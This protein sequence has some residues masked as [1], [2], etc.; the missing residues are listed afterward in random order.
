M[1]HSMKFSYL[2]LF[3][4]FMT[5]LS[6]A[7]QDVNNGISVNEILLEYNDSR[8]LV[9][10]EQLADLIIKKDPSLRLID[11]RDE[12]QFESFS[13]PW[14]QNVPLK[15]FLSDSA[16]DILDCDKYKIVCYSNSN[17][18]A[19]RAWMVKR[20]LGCS[21]VYI[22]SGGL[23]AW[24]ENILQPRKPG[25]LASSDEIE[26]YKMRLAMQNY[27]L[28]LSQELEEVPFTRPVPKKSIVVVPKK[29]VEDEEEEGC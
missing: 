14:A 18:L 16:K 22:L 17:I 7:E 11:V 6:C 5:I 12:G 10:P 8:R 29:V 24:V 15:E 20:Q 25:E 3:L 9:T 27:F 13:L 21:N 1:K 19:D 2:F 26:S 23:N 28:G 4:L